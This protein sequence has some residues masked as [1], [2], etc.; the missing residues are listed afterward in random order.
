MGCLLD[1]TTGGPQDTGH[2]TQTAQL[3]VRYFSDPS[4]DNPVRKANTLATESGALK[5]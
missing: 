1:F 2:T 3:T 5:H 4:L